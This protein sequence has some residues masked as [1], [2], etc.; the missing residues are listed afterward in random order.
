M[1]LEKKCQSL[2]LFILGENYQGGGLKLPLSKIRFVI[3]LGS[4]MSECVSKHLG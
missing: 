1:N 4:H 3:K 2:I